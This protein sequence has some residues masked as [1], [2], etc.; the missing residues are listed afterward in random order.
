MCTSEEF[1]AADRQRRHVEVLVWS[2]RYGR[3]PTSGICRRQREKETAQ[4]KGTEM[5]G[6]ARTRGH[7]IQGNDGA[8]IYQLHMDTIT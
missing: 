4:K 7:G 2:G 1:R 3:D 5:R 6:R 8:L